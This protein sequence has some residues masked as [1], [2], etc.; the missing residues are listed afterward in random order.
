MLW[1]VMD[2]TVEFKARRRARFNPG[3][4]DDQDDEDWD[5]SDHHG[6]DNERQR[7]QPRRADGPYDEPAI[8]MG[9]R[10]AQRRQPCMRYGAHRNPFRGNAPQAS[11]LKMDM[12][13]VVVGTGSCPL[14]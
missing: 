7:Q 8:A 9:G 1:V 10:D 13:W 11:N 5:D 6:D 2:S 3:G 14:G 12:F 4:Q